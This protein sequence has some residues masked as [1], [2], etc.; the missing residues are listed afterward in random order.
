VLQPVLSFSTVTKKQALAL[1]NASEKNLDTD[2]LILSN[3]SFNYVNRLRMCLGLLVAWTIQ[4]NVRNKT[5][6]L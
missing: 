1:G 5:V 4:K 6:Q 3:I 2:S